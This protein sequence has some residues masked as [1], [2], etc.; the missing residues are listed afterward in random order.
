LELPHEKNCTPRFAAS[1][2]RAPKSGRRTP[3]ERPAHEMGQGCL[4]AIGRRGSHPI[5][6][7]DRP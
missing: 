1:N 2:I 7:D 6:G 4:S 3:A 5:G